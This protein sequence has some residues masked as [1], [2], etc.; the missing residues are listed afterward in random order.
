MKPQVRWTQREAK[1]SSTHVCPK[2]GDAKSL[3]RFAED[4]S[5]CKSCEASK[6]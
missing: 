2:C 1:R 3:K 4:S 6:K 5:I